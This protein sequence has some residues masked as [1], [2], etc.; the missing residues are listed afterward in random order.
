M[1]QKILFWFS[2]LATP[3]LYGQGFIVDQQSTNLMEGGAGIQFGQPIGQSFTPTFSS[4]NFVQLML[5]DP[6]FF[7]TAG[8]T[9]FVNLRSNSISGPIISSTSAIFFPDGFLGVSN[10]QFSASID[11]SPGMTYYL[12]PVIQSGD[13][14]AAFITDGSY[15][16]GSEFYQGALVSSQNLW[17]QEGIIATP[18]PSSV[19]L[20]VVGS[21][22]VVWYRRRNNL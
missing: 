12:Q 6:N 19:A 17:F 20:I 1:K 13:D 10:F 15:A 14:M 9:I 11:L 5:F 22:L 16:G 7:N 21:G 4:I 18:E 2:L 3:F 8:S